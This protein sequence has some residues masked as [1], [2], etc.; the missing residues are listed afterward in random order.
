M[1]TSVTSPQDVIPDITSLTDIYLINNSGNDITLSLKIGPAMVKAV[2]EVKLETKTILNGQEGQISDQKIGTNKTVN[3]KFLTIKTV[4][5]HILGQ[6]RNISVVLQI[7]GGEE[8]VT[9]P[10][11]HAQIKNDGDTIFFEIEIFFIN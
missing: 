10:P 3:S 7:K 1:A 8:T 9:Y 2:S 5:T 6:P 11:L 4:A